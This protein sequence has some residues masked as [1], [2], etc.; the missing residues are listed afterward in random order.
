M[1]I[2]KTLTIKNSEPIIDSS[3]F[4]RIYFEKLISGQHITTVLPAE[5][6]GEVLGTLKEPYLSSGQIIY[7][8]SSM[9]DGELIWVAD[10][11]TI[12]SYNLYKND[13]AN[14][15]SSDF[16][17]SFDTSEVALTVVEEP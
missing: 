2:I 11:D 14:L 1:R 16:S 17:T 5:V 12:E 6:I 3:E 4:I 15:F 13:L 7:Q 9:I 10:F 8:D